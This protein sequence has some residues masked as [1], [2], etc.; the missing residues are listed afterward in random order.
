MSVGMSRAHLVARGEL[1]QEGHTFGSVGNGTG[2]IDE[3]VETGSTAR[4]HQ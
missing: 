1:S 2:D 4:E 3:G